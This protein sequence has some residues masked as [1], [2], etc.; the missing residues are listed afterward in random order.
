QASLNGKPEKDKRS[1]GVE[2]TTKR[3][4]ALGK[5]KNGADLLTIIDLYD[6]EGKNM[7][8][9]V[10]IRVPGQYLVTDFS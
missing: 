10:V 5:V 7:G 9:R 1:M 2:I 4:N 3:L 6:D 8:T